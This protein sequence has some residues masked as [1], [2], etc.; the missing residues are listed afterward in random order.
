MSSSCVPVSMI[1]PSSRTTI[2]SASRIVES[3]CA[4][5]KAVRSA[6][7]RWSACWICRSVS[8]VDR[9]GRLVQDQ[10][11]RVGEQR[12]G[13]REQL[14]LPAGEPRA[15]LLHLGLVPLEPQ[16]ELVRADRLRRRVDL[17]AV[18]PRACRRRCS[19]ATVPAKRNVSCRTTRSGGA[20]TPGHVAEVDAVDRDRARRGGRR[21]A[22][23]SLTMWTCRHRSG[24]R[25]RRSSPAASRGRSRAAPRGRLSRSPKW[26]SSKRTCPSIRGGPR[27]RPCGSLH[28]GLLVHH[29]HDLVP[30]RPQ[31][32]GTCCR[33]AR[34][35]APGRRSSTDRSMKAKSV[36]MEDLVVEEGDCRRTRGRLRSPPRR[37]NPRRGST[38]RS[39]TTVCWFDSPVPPGSPRR[40]CRSCW[41]FAS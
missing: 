25:A 15:A 1:R 36:P 3:R 9:R 39:G 6:S 34:A 30:A 24:R 14:P 19:P 5:T 13:E 20:A 21:S 31:R 11:P 41:S 38:G 18:S 33:A 23:R 35:A 10:D 2:S 40:N 17:L 22:A 12:A 28:L 26:T 16:D 4:M 37:G 7:R 32:T 29:V 8:A 27:G